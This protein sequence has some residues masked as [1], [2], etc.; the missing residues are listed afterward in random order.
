MNR[1]IKKVKIKSNGSAL[2][3]LIVFLKSV[4]YVNA[5][6]FLASFCKNKIK[7]KKLTDVKK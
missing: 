5:S 2:L 6:L 1:I 3:C 7:L 4:K